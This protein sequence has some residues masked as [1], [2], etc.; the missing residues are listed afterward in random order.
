MAHLRGSFRPEFL[1]R[2][3][4]II[5]FHSLTEHEIIQ[6]V[7]L[8]LDRLQNALQERNISLE[9]TD[10]AKEWLAE[11]GYDPEYGARP[12]RRLI[13]KTVENLASSAILRGDFDEGDTMVVDV[14]DGEI[15]LR[16]P[17]E[18]AA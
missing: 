5:V 14:E 15:A 18:Q 6:I 17:G 12:L 3:D 8:M 2:I 11:R 9:T 7:D 10:D 16:K 1:N 13:Q 4:E